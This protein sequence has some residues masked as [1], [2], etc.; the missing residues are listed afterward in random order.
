MRTVS[1]IIPTLNRG[2]IAAE[3][4]RSLQKQEYPMFDVTLVDQSEASPVEFTELQ[5]DPRV[6]VIH[7][8]TPGTCRA[9]NAG[10]AAT[11]GEVMV[12]LDDDAFPT[13]P[14][15][16]SVHA[17]AYDDPNVAGVA[18][19]VVEENDP[20][21]MRG[22]LL[23]VSWAGE[24][25]PNAAGTA[26]SWVSHA[27]GGNMSF[28]RSV[29]QRAGRFDERFR[30]NA[31]REETDYSL[32]V[33][34]KGGRI[35]FLPD[36]EVLHRRHP[37]GGSRGFD[38]MRWYADFF[39]NE[40]LFFGKHFP[41]WKIPMLILRKL[42]PILACSLYYGRG[43]GSAILLPWVNFAAGFRAASETTA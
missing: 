29:I 3:L 10:I 1:V 30:G 35:L 8:E 34:E 4:V 28:R 36:A 25:H 24:V 15:F 7:R 16:L 27:R 21:A 39:F 40:A 37:T 38:R 26:R 43:K 11:K 32:R 23:S 42:R 6:R 18:G 13:S 12:F 33:V 5:R 2:A 20:A 41:H 31:M 17:A 14:R 19:R 9:R 22:P